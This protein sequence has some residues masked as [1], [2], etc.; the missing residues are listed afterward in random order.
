MVIQ[1]K[2]WMH[3]PMNHPFEW[4]FIYRVTEKGRKTEHLTIYEY[5]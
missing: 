3:K 4:E 2:T 5:K 1:L